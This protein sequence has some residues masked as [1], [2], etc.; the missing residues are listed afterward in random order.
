MSSKGEIVKRARSLYYQSIEVGTYYRNLA[1][2][3]MNFPHGLAA[4]GHFQALRL[5]GN[6]TVLFNVYTPFS[7]PQDPKFIEARKQWDKFLILF[8]KDIASY[9]RRFQ[10]GS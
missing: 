2:P 4:E 10:C 5:G 3:L 9:L 1:F 8:T 7:N 6:H